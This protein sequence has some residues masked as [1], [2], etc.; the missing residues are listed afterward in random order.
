MQLFTIY[1]FL[2]TSCLLR[3]THL[4]RFEIHADMALMQKCG[5]KFCSTWGCLCAF[6]RG[7]NTWQVGAC[8]VPL[9]MIIHYI[10]TYFPVNES[11]HSHYDVAPKNSVNIKHQIIEVPVISAAVPTNQ[12]QYECILYIPV[13]IKCI[14]T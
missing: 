9:T 3:D 8:T 12:H 14:S 5:N 10:D 4:V 13:D 7:N 11:I 1:V 2:L 6:K